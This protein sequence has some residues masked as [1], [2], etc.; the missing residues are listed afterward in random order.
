MEFEPPTSECEGLLR[1]IASNGGAYRKRIISNFP[2]G[3][4]QLRLHSGI[5]SAA[6]LGIYEGKARIKVCSLHF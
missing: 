1:E 3:V 5:E 2:G 4:R 6:S